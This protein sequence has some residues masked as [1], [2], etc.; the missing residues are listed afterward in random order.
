MVQSILPTN[1]HAD[2]CEYIPYTPALDIYNSTACIPLIALVEPTD[3]ALMLVWETKKSFHC[4]PSSVTGCVYRTP[5]LNLYSYN[6]AGY[7]GQ[8]LI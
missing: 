6:N 4:R 3:V 5:L 2:I 8:K 7:M 1:G